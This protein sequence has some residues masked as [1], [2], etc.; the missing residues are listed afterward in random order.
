VKG[1]YQVVKH[2]ANWDA[3]YSE[4]VVD[5]LPTMKAALVVRQELLAKDAVQYGGIKWHAYTIQTTGDMQ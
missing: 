4:V 3:Q 2:W 1:S 5:G